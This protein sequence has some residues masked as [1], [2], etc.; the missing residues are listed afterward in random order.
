[1]TH[2]NYYV[3][4]RYSF[5]GAPQCVNLSML[6]GTFT[7]LIHYRHSQSSRVIQYRIRLFDQPSLHWPPFT[8]PPI[9]L[10]YFPWIPINF[11]HIPP[12]TY[13][14]EAVYS[15]Q[16]T[17]Q[18]EYLW[19]ECSNLRCHREIL[20]TPQSKHL[21]SGIDLRRWCHMGAALHHCAALIFSFDYKIRQR[22]KINHLLWEHM[23]VVIQKWQNQFP[24]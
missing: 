11:A 14:L 20:Q 12:L 18:P 9:I 8:Q 21:R 2:V 1:M 3:K 17:C 6:L 5:P 15:G 24:M 23:N 22:F 10:F 13:A 4:N 16:L 19:D 7:I